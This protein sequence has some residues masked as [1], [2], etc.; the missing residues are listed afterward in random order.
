MALY[1]N[2]LLVLLYHINQCSTFYTDQFY[3]SRS[4]ERYP[5]RGG[6]SNTG[7]GCGSFFLVISNIFSV[8][9][10]YIGTA[11]SYK[12]VSFYTDQFY[13]NRSNNQ[14]Y[15]NRGAGCA[16]NLNCGA[17]YINMVAAYDYSA[18]SFG[19]TLSYKPVFFEYY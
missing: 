3:Q 19:A 12:P 1:I 5:F 10:W 8:N 13:P 4:N 18:R 17:F 6:R 14:F 2:G 7:S 11:L 15:P 9:Y 16:S